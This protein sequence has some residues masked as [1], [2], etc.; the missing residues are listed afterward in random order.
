M[1]VNKSILFRDYV[2]SRCVRICL[3][4]THIWRGLVRLAARPR[5]NPSMQWYV[6]VELASRQALRTAA[7]AASHLCQF[8]VVPIAP[9]GLETGAVLC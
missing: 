4:S 5:I 9:L 1:V 2:I 3:R 7:H 8:K 6:K